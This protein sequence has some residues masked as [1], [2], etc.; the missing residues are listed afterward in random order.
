MTRKW[1][2]VSVAVVFSL[3]LTSCLAGQ[4][5]GKKQGAEGVAAE[6][7]ESPSPSD[8]D[9]RLNSDEGDKDRSSRDNAGDNRDRDNSSAD[10]Q[11]CYKADEF[12]CAIELAITKQ[13]N[14]KR[15]GLQPMRYSKSLSYVSRQWSKAMA[16]RGRIGHQG[17]PSD[18]LKDFI[19]E[20]GSQPRMVSENV[21]YTF[22]G[23]GDPERIARQLT[24]M[25]WSSAGHRRN[26]IQ[27]HPAIGVGIWREGNRVY[28]TQIFG[29][30]RD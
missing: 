3:F 29:D 5:S 4:K 16:D 9:R 17:F 18:R 26:M 10:D 28:G 12:I 2:L 21:A 19:A 24:D 23:S 1:F 27:L 14:E 25:W 7:A 15:G 11:R 22:A 8:N 30:A 6:P 20:F 13:T